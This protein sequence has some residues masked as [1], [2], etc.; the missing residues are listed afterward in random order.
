MLELQSNFSLYLYFY[1]EAMVE[2]MHNEEATEASVLK[3]IT[4][5]L[6]DLNK[7]VM[8]T[9]PKINLRKPPIVLGYKEIYK[10]KDVA[11]NLP[12]EYSVQGRILRCMRWK[13]ATDAAEAK[14]DIPS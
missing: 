4:M 13:A 1:E 6:S 12:N 5:S 11:I 2:I 8:N 9:P 7:E 10:E 3:T 14:Y